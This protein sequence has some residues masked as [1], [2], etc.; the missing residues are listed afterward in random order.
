VTTGGT[1]I[2]INTASI[3]PAQGLSF[4]MASNTARLVAGLLIR[5]GRVKRSYLGVGG[6]T[7]AVPRA[8]ARSLQLAV[9]SGVLVHSVEPSSPSA[10]AG[11]RSGDVIIACGGR[12][13]AAIA[14]LHR[15]LTEDLVGV[16]TPVTIIR[17][18]TRRQLVV[19]PADS[20][21]D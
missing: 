11:L 12:P 13:V 3:V 6:Q 7:V 5:D 19:V 17:A 10:H 4:A 8:L 20:Q 14:D 18:S 1:V 2:G 16:P 9:A 21:R 15:S